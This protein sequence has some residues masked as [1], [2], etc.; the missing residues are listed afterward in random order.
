MCRNAVCVA[1]PDSSTTPYPSNPN[2]FEDAPPTSTG[3]FCIILADLMDHSFCP[4]RLFDP[5]S[6]L[7]SLTSSRLRAWRLHAS[8][9]ANSRDWTRSMCPFKELRDRSWLGCWWRE[10]GWL[11]RAVHRLDDCFSSYESLELLLEDSRCHSWMAALTKL[12]RFEDSSWPGQSAEVIVSKSY[13]I[14][15]SKHTFDKSPSIWFPLYN[16]QPLGS[17]SFHPSFHPKKNTKRLE[18]I[19]WVV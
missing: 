8:L 18:P 3:H 15:Q 13:T 6:K 9:K 19:P 14:T 12:L 11:E 5:S 10:S 1:R 2:V 16:T 17:T 4:P 7:L